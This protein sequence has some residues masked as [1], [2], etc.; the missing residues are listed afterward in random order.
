MI[1]STCKHHMTSMN[2][3]PS[4]DER[5]VHKRFGEAWHWASARCRPSVRPMRLTAQKGGATGGGFPKNAL[6]ITLARSRLSL[7]ASTAPRCQDHLI[8]AAPRNFRRYRS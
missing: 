4:L 8:V 5:W 6:E 1:V 2:G 3:M 7:A